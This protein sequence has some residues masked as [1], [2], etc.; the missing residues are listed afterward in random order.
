MM[1]T[2]IVVIILFL[3]RSFLFITGEVE[4]ANQLSRFTGKDS[5]VVEGIYYTGDSVYDFIEKPEFISDTQ[6]IFFIG[7]SQRKGFWEGFYWDF[8]SE[9]NTESTKSLF[10]EMARRKPFCI[11]HLG[12]LTSK[13]SS[14]S[15]WHE[16]EEDNKSVLDAK[17]PYFPV[18]GNHEYHGRNDKC[19]RN[20][21]EHF[22]YISGR[23]WYSVFQGNICIIL[24]NSN[25]SEL[26]DDEISEQKKWY[27]KLLRKTDV[28]STISHVIVCSHYPPFT[29]S[30]IV[31]PSVEI[32]RDFV[33]GF[34]KYKK[35]ILFLSGHS[36]SYEK[37]IEQGK[38]FIISGGG[39]G[40]R[41]K[42][43]IDPNTRKYDDK[44]NGDELRFFHFCELRKQKNK[45]CFTV[46]K[47]DNNGT[48][49][50]ADEFNF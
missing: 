12:D 49:S 44:Y 36:H 4:T 5:T 20:F 48:F 26:D 32:L 28:D 35:T 11:I 8:W 23:K 25:Y 41:H 40:P 30:N 46:Y 19:Y 38:Y 10:Y 27:T 14:E 47:L 7:D 34:L 33:P 21:Y 13:G 16:F 42:L 18:F 22:P 2:S 9:N 1:I 17:I 24:L 43:N 45:L 39:G 6:K 31:S 3:L 15:S 37:F 29:N 50:I